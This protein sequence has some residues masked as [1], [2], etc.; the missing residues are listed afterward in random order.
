MI[1]LRPL[2]WMLP[3]LLAAQAR[4]DVVPV[5][6]GVGNGVNAVIKADGPLTTVNLF[7][8]ARIEWQDFNLALG[9]ELRYVSQNGGAFPSLNIVRS[10]VP[11]VIDGK[12]TADGPFYLISPGGLQVGS[13]GRIEAPRVLLSTL[14]PADGAKLLADG[15]GTFAPDTSGGM[16]GV[17]GTIETSG[18]PLIVLSSTISTGG[19]S[20]L[21]SAGGDVRLA[22]VDT[23]PVQVA[24]SG[25]PLGLRTTGGSG[26]INTTGW[27][28]A[29]R[30]EIVSDGFI[31]N[32]GRITSLGQGNE[33]RLAASDVSHE[34]RPDD[35]SVIITSSLRVDGQF[36]Q[37]GPVL[38]P[39]DGANPAVVAGL[40]QTPRLSSEGFITKVEPGQTQ[41][42]TAP[43]Q[44][45][46]S[47]AS[48]LPPPL[49]RSPA[50][51]ARRGDGTVKKA[52]FFGQQVRH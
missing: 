42:S 9:R 19:Q 28:D 48:A 45:P 35:S 40:R 12:I 24:P 44:T 41:L 16:V 20:R 17:D 34:L 30:V 2:R 5:P 46:Q 47:T 52:A 25:G 38:R 15:S 10:P 23:T 32:G 33:V 7:G 14:M 43:L 49:R 1:P 29:R 31:V 11:S 36:R 27:I 37:I 51:A 18:G 13:N 6:A 21:R 39:S 22:A 8:P 3:V 4:A 50:L 26:L